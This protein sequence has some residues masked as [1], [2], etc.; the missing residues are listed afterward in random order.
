MI[1]DYLDMVLLLG[2]SQGVFLALTLLFVRNRNAAANRVL[3]IFLSISVVMLIGRLLYV[4]F[5]NDLLLYRLGT[6]VDSVVFL[7]GPMLYLY[8]RRLCFAEDPPFRFRRW[9][10]LPAILHLGFVLYTCL[11]YTSPSPRD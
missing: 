11:L 8:C 2:I 9:V 7:F 10:F 1:F 4:R 3:S 5:G 6:L